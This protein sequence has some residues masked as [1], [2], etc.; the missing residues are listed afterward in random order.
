MNTLNKTIPNNAEKINP[1]MVLIFIIKLLN[2]GFCLL[3]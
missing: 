3:F 1:N 2:P